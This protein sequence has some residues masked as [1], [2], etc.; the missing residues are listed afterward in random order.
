[1]KCLLFAAL[2]ITGLSVA[3]CAHAPETYG[4]ARGPEPLDPHH[5]DQNCNR[6]QFPQCG[7][8]M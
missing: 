6:V 3:G 1:M 4:S 8:S 2:V 7:G 5:R